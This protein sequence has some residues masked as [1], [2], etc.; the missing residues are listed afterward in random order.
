MEIEIAD[1]PRKIINE[2]DEQYVREIILCDELANGSGFVN[3]LYHTLKNDDN[4]FN[5]DKIISNSDSF[6]NSAIATD[7]HEEEC[8]TACYKCLKVFRN[9]QFHDM[10]DWR[11]GA[12]ILKIMDDPKYLIGLDLD[13]KDTANLPLELKSY[14]KDAKFY[15]ELLFENLNKDQSIELLPINTDFGIPYF[16]V[17]VYK[18]GIPVQRRITIIHPLWNVG[19]DGWCGHLA[20]IQSNHNVN[21]CIDTFNLKK[22]FSECYKQILT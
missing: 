1:I 7:E 5:L 20:S 10:L 17:K 4:S 21:I 22:R 19:T 13:L 3:R 9:M 12:S 2:L 8:D 15:A 18:A 11:L 14:F 6:Y 16:D